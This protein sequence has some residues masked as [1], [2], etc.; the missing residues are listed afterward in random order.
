VLPIAL[1]LLAGCVSQ[2]NETV[3]SQGRAL[4]FEPLDGCLSRQAS[5]LDKV[6]R[7]EAEWTQLWRQACG[8]GS[9]LNVMA[10]QGQEAPPPEVDFAAHSVVP[11]FWG[12]KP[13]GG[14]G[15]SIAS[16]TE[17]DAEVVVVVVHTTAP[18][19]GLG[20]GAQQVGHVG[21]QAAAGAS[22]PKR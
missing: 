14:F 16:I 17:H 9:V 12:Q 1:V 15:V 5:P 6:V 2:G 4:A 19:P 22:A 7:T 21:L 3:P 10:A 20:R 11:S 13:N 8:D 18:A